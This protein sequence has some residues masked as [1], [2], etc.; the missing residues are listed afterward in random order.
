M[1]IRRQ[2]ITVFIDYDNVDHRVR[3]RGV[4]RVI[5]AV[6]QSCWNGSDARSLGTRCD[7]WIDVGGEVV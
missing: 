7:S 6:L 2:Q 3:R 1:R 5:R 4:D